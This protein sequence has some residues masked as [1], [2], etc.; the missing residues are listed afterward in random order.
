MTHIRNPLAFLALVLSLCGGRSAF[1]AASDEARPTTS[2]SSSES[3]DVVTKTGTAVAS[4][5]SPS[6]GPAVVIRLSGEVD[7]YNRDQ[8]VRRFQRARAAGAKT[9]ILEIDTYGGLVTAGLDISRFLK[10]QTDLRVIAYVDSKA[11]SAGAMIALA[12]DEIVMAPSGT[13]GDCAPIQTAPGVGMVTMGQTERAKIESPILAD[14][15][16]SAER[17]GYS[18]ELVVA[19]VST[20][21][22]VY[23][24]QDREG[25]RK[26]VD[27]EAYQKLSA[28][29]EW[30]PVAGEPTPLDGPETLLT[31]HTEQAVRY[32]LAKGVA[33]SAEALAS[34]RG[35]TILDRY[36]DGAGDRFVSLLGS[37]G[38]RIL[39]LIVFVN[40]LLLALKT[41]GS[42][43][44]EAIA[45]V[46]FGLLVGVPLLTGYAQW[47]EIGMILVGIGL[48]AFE[49]FVFPGH[50]VSVILGTLLLG[51]GLTLT[52]V[53]DF[54]TVPGGWSLPGTLAAA[55]Y[56]LLVTVGGVAAGMA[57]FATFYRFL[58]KIPYYNRL[59]LGGAGRRPAAGAVVIVP[60]VDPADHW[61]FVGT[62][63]TAVTDLRPGGTVGFPFGAD[64]RSASV[65]SEDGYVV[66][67]TRVIVRQVEGNRVVVRVV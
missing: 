60:Q 3:A 62:V 32:G 63:G 51:A 7:D 58:A 24:V 9:V 36:A 44:P 66:A 52:F 42:G 67:G 33:A 48:I 53:G 16:E 31:V 46:S 2:P 29:G 59:I 14:F 47:W 1:A 39:F 50:L 43:P 35:M 40:A 4:T 21:R 64:Q 11:I 34:Q 6:V 45:V 15:M 23:W 19:M 12:C 61:P 30:K 10:N 56:G 20:A 25:N 17:N 54:W 37:T 22:S 38:A 57:L 28:G 55:K 65:V 49:V 41:P 18:R 26:F 8:L 13:L 27:G 5:R